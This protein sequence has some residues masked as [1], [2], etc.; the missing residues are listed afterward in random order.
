MVF[1]F[2]GTKLLI[3]NW[4]FGVVNQ[5]LGEFV[6]GQDFVHLLFEPFGHELKDDK[7]NDDTD[8]P[9]QVGIGM[10]GDDGFVCGEAHKLWIERVVKKWET[11]RVEI[12]PITKPIKLPI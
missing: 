8:T 3:F 4:S 9:F 11:R 1:S 12:M 7:A 5:P 10:F 2:A 6:T